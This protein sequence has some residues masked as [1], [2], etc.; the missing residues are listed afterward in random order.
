MSFK[1]VNNN[2]LI[3]HNGESMEYSKARKDVDKLKREM[4][5]LQSQY[6]STL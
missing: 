1:A 5:N 3:V 4:K 6:K 2:G